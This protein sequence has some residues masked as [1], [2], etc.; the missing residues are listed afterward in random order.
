[1]NYSSDHFNGKIFL[2]PVP[3]NVMGKGAFMRIMKMYRQNY[4]DRT[5]SRPP[6]PFHADLNL[7]N[8]LP[9]DTLRLTWLGHSSCLIEVDGKRF[10]TDPLWYQRASPFTAVGPKLFFQNP[11]PIHSLPPVD[12]ILLSH[13]HYDHLDRQSILYLISK[14]IPVITFLGVGKRLTDWGADKSLVTELDWWQHMELNNGLIVTA[15]PS[16]HF[17]GRWINDRFSTLWGSFAIKGQSIM[18]ILVQTPAIM[19]DLKISEISLGLL[20]LLCLIAVLIIRSGKAYIW[21][22]RMQYEFILISR[23]N[24]LMPVH[25]G[26]FNLAFHPWTEPVERVIKAAKENN[27]QLIL[28]APGE[29]RNADDGAYNSKWWEGYM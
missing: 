27:V 10:L 8:H 7:L 25:W 11:V 14:K 3:T 17:S 4:P 28:P 22:L 29:T 5:P 12:Y 1:M 19:M 26:T 9:A 18:F 23:G 16:R 15:L 13:D 20:I 6:G 2:N 24:S 21:D